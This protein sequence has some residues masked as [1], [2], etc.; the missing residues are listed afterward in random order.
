MAF[1]DRSN[2]MCATPGCQLRV[3]SDPSFG[4]YCCCKCWWIQVNNAKPKKKH[5][6]ACEHIEL[7]IDSIK[8]QIDW[9][10]DGCNG[11]DEPRSQLPE[12]SLNGQKALPASTTGRVPASS[13]AAM[14]TS[15]A[16][17]APTGLS[18]EDIRNIDNLS[19][20]DLWKK[21]WSYICDLSAATKEDITEDAIFEQSR[22][23][24]YY[25]LQYQEDIGKYHQALSASAVQKP[26]TVTAMVPVSTAA[27]VLEHAPT[28]L[29][30][31]G[32]PRLPELLE[33]DWLQLPTEESIASAHQSAWSRGYNLTCLPECVVPGGHGKW[34][35]ALWCRCC[36][37]YIAWLKKA[38]SGNGE[39]DYS[40]DGGCPHFFGPNY[41]DLGDGGP[42]NTNGDGSSGRE[43]QSLPLLESSPSSSPSKSSFPPPRSGMGPAAPSTLTYS[44]WGGANGH[45]P[46]AFQPGPS[47][48]APPGAWNGPPP[49]RCEDPMRNED[50]WSRGANNPQSQP[51][52]WQPAPKSKGPP[53]L[54]TQP[55]PAKG[56]N[57]WSNYPTH[58]RSLGPPPPQA[59][60]SAPW[61]AAP[62]KAPPGGYPQEPQ[63]AQSTSGWLDPPGPPGQTPSPPGFSTQESV[64]GTDN[65]WNLP[66]K[67]APGT[68]SMRTAVPK[69][70]PAKEG[71]PS[72]PP[73]GWRSQALPERMFKTP[74]PDSKSSPKVPPLSKSPPTTQ[75]PQ[76]SSGLAPNEVD[77]SELMAFMQG[78]GDQVPGPPPGL[79]Q[80][81]GIPPP[82]PKAKA[83]P[84]AFS[85]SRPA[86]NGAAHVSHQVE[87]WVAAPPR[88][89][90]Q[91]LI[92]GSAWANR[93]NAPQSNGWGWPAPG[94]STSAP[95]TA[96]RVLPMP[97]VTPGALELPPELKVS[98]EQLRNVEDTTLVCLI[99]TQVVHNPV[100]TRC[101]HLFCYDC[102]KSWVET[103]SK[104]KALESVA[105]P[106]CNE[107]LN[108]N[109]VSCLSEDSTAAHGLLWRLYQD[110][111]VKCAYHHEVDS[112]GKCSW[113][114]KFKAY[115]QH[116]LLECECRKEAFQQNSL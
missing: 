108:E 19:P 80:E 16:P 104:A 67:A 71:G 42:D 106:T 34:G 81:Q 4:G 13:M 72:S 102:M 77:L 87:E 63:A 109:D 84:P 49:G 76:S 95:S 50:P 28:Q 12:A 82:P 9:Y 112:G 116:V 5:G 111:I 66:S 47:G 15:A 83:P 51:G 115:P 30:R 33:G 46:K 21:A 7:P 60:Q 39:M 58:D 11:P 35:V 103:S 68:V 3:N 56:G 23:V 88:S 25:W 100:V 43:R 78:P 91:Q 105:C 29:G 65:P 113:Q 64:S 110:Q 14:P 52:S 44:E 27:T 22:K 24:W 26:E 31:D 53:S 40:R 37:M 94:V 59:M 99:C 101:T 86:A 20:E 54:L 38:T 114:G 93:M 96:S 18:L 32:P 75:G 8:A 85:G 97:V 2:L 1:I 74:P 69:R 41:Y 90:A 57:A 107:Q 92:P 73:E 61:S 6:D 79:Q 45:Q 10:P 70:G 17:E 48:N 98:P 89:G 55:S 62:P 36:N